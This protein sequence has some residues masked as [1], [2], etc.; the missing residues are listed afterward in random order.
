MAAP[1]SIPNMTLVSTILMMRTYAIFNRSRLVLIILIASYLACFVPSFVYFFV[2]T[3]HGLDA[4]SVRLVAAIGMLKGMLVKRGVDLTK[5]W[6][7]LTTCFY[8]GVPEPLGSV[9]IS[10]LIYESEF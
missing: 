9:M 5:D 6:W 1:A 8:P 10:G 4:D 2:V 3:R 7:V